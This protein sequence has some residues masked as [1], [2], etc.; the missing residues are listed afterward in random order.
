M[1]WENA[2]ATFICS[3]L[4]TQLWVLNSSVYLAFGLMFPKWIAIEFCKL[5]IITLLLKYL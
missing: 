1:G 5:F 4:L 2:I 3:S